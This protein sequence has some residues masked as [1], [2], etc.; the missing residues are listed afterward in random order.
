MPCGTWQW[1]LMQIQ[2]ILC[3]RNH[4]A[5]G[6]VTV[7][8]GVVFAGSVA[9]NGPI[10]M[11]WMQIL[12]RFY[13]RVIHQC[14]CLWRCFIKLWVHLPRKWSYGQPGKV[15]PY[16]DSSGTSL[17]AFCDVWMRDIRV[18]T[19]NCQQLYASGEWKKISLRCS[20]K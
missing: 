13:G 20:M 1:F 6:P 18:K 16:L 9:S 11:P 15:P 5:L 14:Y 7:N 2:W 4:N 17:F 8:N 10:Y 3:V 19:W 12:E